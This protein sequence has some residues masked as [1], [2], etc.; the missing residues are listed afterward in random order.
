VAAP[1]RSVPDRADERRAPA[2]RA[3]RCGGDRAATGCRRERARAPA[4]AASPELMAGQRNPYRPGTASYARVRAAGLKS[5]AAL[6][7]A[8]AARAKTPETRR[9]AQQ[10]RSAAQKALRAIE[11][12]AEFRSQPNEKDRSTFDRLSIAQQEQ[13]SRVTRRFPDRVPSDFPDPFPG[14]NRSSSWRLYYST[15]AGIRLQALV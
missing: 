5:R 15:R 13:I 2:L 6:A 11:R 10:Q 1:R 8:T 3:A 14:P 4:K 9:R 7:A 12:R